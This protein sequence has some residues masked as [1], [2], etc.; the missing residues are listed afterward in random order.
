MERKK[1]LSKK[2]YLGVDMQ[3][4]IFKIAGNEYNV[5]YSKSNHYNIAIN[6]K[7]FAVELLNKIQGNVFSFA[8]NQKLLQVELDF[9]KEGNLN[10][11]L[12]GFYYDVEITTQM[13]KL[14]EKFIIQSNSAIAGTRI[15]KAPMPGMVIKC[16]VEEGNH[17][18]EGDKLVII[19]AM[20]MENAFKSPVTGVVKSIR[21]KEGKPVNKDDFLLEI[22]II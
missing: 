14:L 7:I 17:V 21:A 8:V 19:E 16:F 6:D 22:E 2:K 11:A 4:L 9:N 12:D 3:D 5:K 1:S 13:K 18:M 10:I 15:V 20:K